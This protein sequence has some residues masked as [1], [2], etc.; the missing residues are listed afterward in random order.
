MAKDALHVARQ[1]GGGN[2]S[3]RRRELRNEDVQLLKDD[4]FLPR[5]CAVR[6]R[7]AGRTF[8]K[9]RFNRGLKLSHA[10]IAK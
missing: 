4:A 10:R 8:H 1:P 7:R 2:T 5:I 3:Q 6:G 9:R